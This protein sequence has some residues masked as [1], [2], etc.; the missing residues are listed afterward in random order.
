MGLLGLAMMQ[1][2]RTRAESGHGV[3]TD[4]ADPALSAT[5]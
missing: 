3:A 2:A 4:H 1:L 5:H